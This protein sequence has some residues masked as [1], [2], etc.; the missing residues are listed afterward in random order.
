VSAGFALHDHTGNVGAFPNAELLVPE[1]ELR[2]LTGPLARRAQFAQHVEPA[3][4]EGI[5][6]AER[7]GR[8]RAIAGR[9]EVA[10]G[11]TA[12]EVGG[13]SPGQQIVVVE[14]GGAP[15]ALASDAVH[16]YEEYD[17]DRPFAV[18]AD[19]GAM[20]AAYDVL[21]AL[22]RDRGAVMVPG[23]R[24][25]GNGPVPEAGGAAGEIA[26]QLA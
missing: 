8:V 24:P 22:A 16:L 17:R 25:G 10:A 11:V 13:H 12:I 5:A 19:L 15:V 26:V 3:E 6:E 4:I 23:P 9:S 18:V 14:T 21:R 2:F 1:R 7:Q 20:C